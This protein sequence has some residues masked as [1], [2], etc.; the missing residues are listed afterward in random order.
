MLVWC[1]SLC[2]LDFVFLINES[3][4]LVWG[5]CMG[6]CVCMCLCMVSVFVFMC[7]M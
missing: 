4:L 6:V 3:G 1:L 7:M 2:V 5:V